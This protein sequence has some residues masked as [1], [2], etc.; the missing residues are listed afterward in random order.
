MKGEIERGRYGG[1]EEEKKEK[2]ET[3]KGTEGTACTGERERKEERENRKWRVEGE[4]KIWRRGKEG[5]SEGRS[6]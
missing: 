2:V 1:K 6:A 5:G 4:R 3:V